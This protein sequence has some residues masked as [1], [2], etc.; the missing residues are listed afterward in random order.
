[1]DEVRCGVSVVVLRCLCGTAA[2]GPDAVEPGAVVVA[3]V[4]LATCLASDR[5]AWSRSFVEMA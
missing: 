3:G 5:V 4:V 1:L 2:G